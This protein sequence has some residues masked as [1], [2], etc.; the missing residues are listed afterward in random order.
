MSAHAYRWEGG[1]AAVLGGIQPHPLVARADGT[2]DPAEIEAAVKPDDPHFARTRLLCLENTTEGR[3][4]PV[5]YLES[6][7]KLAAG[8]GLATHLDGARLFNAA[9]AAGGDPYLQARRIAEPFDSVSVCFSKGL[10]A[11]VGSVLLG[12]REFVRQA[13]RWRKALGGGLRQAGILAAAALYAL[14]H[15]VQRLAEDHDNAALFVEGLQDL[16][17]LVVGPARTN[18]V[19]ADA[20]AGRTPPDFVERLARGGVLCS[21][22]GRLRFVFHLGVSRADTLA[23]VGIVRAALLP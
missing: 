17:G 2:L 12:S 7:V 4:V 8:L 15:H 21:G 19:Y 20:V 6:T 14:D 22:G 23:A 10:G 3:A 5:E 18:M 9:V 13:L 16:P 11:P 1:G